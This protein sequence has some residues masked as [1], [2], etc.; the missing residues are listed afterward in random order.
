MIADAA[1]T[2][3]LRLRR[4]FRRI[5]SFQLPLRH[6]FSLIRRDA[7]C[8]FATFSLLLLFFAALLMAC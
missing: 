7:D 8:V 6:V 3:P 1:A 5:F 2:M 4:Q